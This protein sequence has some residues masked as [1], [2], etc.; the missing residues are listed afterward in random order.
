MRAVKRRE[1]REHANNVSRRK[2]LKRYTIA[3]TMTNTNDNDRDGATT[4]ASNSRAEDAQARKAGYPRRKSPIPPEQ[5]AKDKELSRR[6]YRI[7]YA[8]PF[9]I[10]AIAMFFY[11]LSRD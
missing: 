9:I 7:I 1:Y 3:P 5:L 8:L 6:L 11:Y 4:A 2:T 10:V